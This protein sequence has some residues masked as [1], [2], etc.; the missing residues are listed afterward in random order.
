LYYHLVWATKNRERLI[1]PHIEERLFSHLLAK[2][3]SL[4]VTV[5][6]INGWYD[7]VHLVVSVPPKLAVADMVKHLKG[8]SAHAMNEAGDLPYHFVWQRGYGAMT[9]GERHRFIAEEYVRNQKEH[10]T[11]QTTN[12]WLE[13]VED[14][15]DGRE[16]AQSD[17]GGK[18]VV[19]ERVATYEAWGEPPF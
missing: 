15:E 10:H 14:V 11:L 7:H 18:T 4:D 8:A 3:A 9:I 16:E 19:R 2:A 5:F 13:Q 17:R 12:R 1:Q 6:A